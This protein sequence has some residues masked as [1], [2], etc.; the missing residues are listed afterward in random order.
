LQRKCKKKF[1]KRK[2]LFG[3][4][5]SFGETRMAKLPPLSIPAPLPPP[6]VADSSTLLTLTAGPVASPALSSVTLSAAQLYSLQRSAMCVQAGTAIGSSVQMTEY[7]YPP[8]AK[9]LV[10][11]FT[12]SNLSGLFSFILFICLFI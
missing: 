4:E 7:G 11:A 8:T 6:T 9:F 10:D 12:G 2:A 1:F 3:R 5:K